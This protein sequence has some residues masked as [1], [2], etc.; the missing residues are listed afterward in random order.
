MEVILDV[1]DFKNKN[2]I[3]QAVSKTLDLFENKKLMRKINSSEDVYVTKIIDT[4]KIIFRK[5]E[6]YGRY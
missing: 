6:C 1:V 3:L 4:N 5:C 2:E